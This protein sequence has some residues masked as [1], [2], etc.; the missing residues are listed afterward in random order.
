[1]TFL[2][3][4]L[5]FSAKNLFALANRPLPFSVSPGDCDLGI[6]RATRLGQRAPTQP[7]PSGSNGSITR[8][9]RRVAYHPIATWTGR[10]PQIERRPMGQ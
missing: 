2:S 8:S 10:G 6:C 1:M 5:Y 7:L 3:R 4:F 9:L